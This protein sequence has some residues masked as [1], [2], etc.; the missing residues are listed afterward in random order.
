MEMKNNSCIVLFCIRFQGDKNMKLKKHISGKNSVV[1]TDNAEK[2]RLRRRQEKLRNDKLRA[3]V[4]RTAI[5]KRKVREA[6]L[7][8][9]PKT[10]R[11]KGYYRFT[12]NYPS[13]VTPDGFRENTP[14][15]KKLSGK[16]RLVLLVICIAIFCLIFTAVNIGIA[17]SEKNTVTKTEPPVINEE[18]ALKGLHITP[19]NL[20]A[21]SSEEIRQM[22]ISEDCNMAVLEF[23]D[24]DGYIYFNTEQSADNPALRMA[25]L[26]FGDEKY[27]KGYEEIKEYCKEHFVDKEDGEWYG[28]LHY[29][30]SVSTT[31]KGNIFKGPFHIP[32]LYI[33]MAVLDECGDIKKYAE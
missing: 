24:E 8:K 28:Y 17:I 13:E 1:Q 29:D 4:I 5:F 19:E 26:Q 25:Y 3:E 22:I 12:K 16:Q 11:T 14:E 32:R 23:K 7:Q 30:N 31:L 10:L 15:S 18:A 6:S 2:I 9:A 20:R 27:L 33:L 21:L